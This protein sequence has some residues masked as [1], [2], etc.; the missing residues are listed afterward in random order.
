MNKILVICWSFVLSIIVF[1]TFDLITT[2]LVYYI[3]GKTLKGSGLNF[4]YTTA[5]YVFITW[6]VGCILIS[7]ACWVVD[8]ETKRLNPPKKKSKNNTESVA[9]AKDFLEKHGIE[10]LK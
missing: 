1:S 6:A 10:T 3:F 7:L 5:A 4:M 8:H 2:N 9:W